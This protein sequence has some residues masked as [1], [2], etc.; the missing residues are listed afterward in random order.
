MNDEKYKYYLTDNIV[1]KSISR[2]YFLSV[3]FNIN[4]YLIAQVSPNTYTQLYE[5]YKM[6]LQEKETKLW[7]N[8][9]IEMLPKIKQ[10][11]DSYLPCQK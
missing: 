7:N 1:L 5:L 6:K 10:K 4:F 9:Q 11:I 8:Y 3:S 2:D